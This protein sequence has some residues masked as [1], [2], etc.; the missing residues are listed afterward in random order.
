[1]PRCGRC[2]KGAKIVDI[3]TVNMVPFDFS[4]CSWCGGRWTEAPPAPAH[5]LD[6]PHPAEGPR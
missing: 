1:M 5:P 2:G 3:I 4:Y 6:A